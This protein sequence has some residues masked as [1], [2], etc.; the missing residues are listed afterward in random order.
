[1]CV[2]SSNI[3]HGNFDYLHLERRSKL[4]F[5]ELQE[6]NYL[7]EQSIEYVLA[8]KHFLHRPQI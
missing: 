4:S 6:I 1:M 5:T 2:K 7:Y 3:L 8:K